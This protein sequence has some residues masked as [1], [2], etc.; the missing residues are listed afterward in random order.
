MKQAYERMVSSTAYSNNVVSWLDPSFSLTAF[1]LVFLPGGHEKSVRQVIASQRVHELLLA[2]KPLIAKPST[3]AVAAIC[4][5]VLV[6]SSTTDAGGVSILRD[7]DTTTLPAE[8]EATA[9]WGT[10]LFLGDYYKTYGAGSESCQDT[11]LNAL[12]DKRQYKHSLAPGDFVVADE[13]ANYL[14]G[15]FPGDAKLLAEMC[16]KMVVDNAAVTAGQQ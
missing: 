16:V 3:H 6:L 7:L 8:F 10:R 11:V 9:Y 1:N 4:H 15:R 5:G 12:G 2:Y 14:S 13:K